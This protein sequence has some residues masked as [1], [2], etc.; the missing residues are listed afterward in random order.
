MGS[1]PFENN[2]HVHSKLKSLGLSD[3]NDSS[4]ENSEDQKAAFEN[5]FGG[6]T[7]S[8]SKRLTPN[9]KS[10]LIS[11][12]SCDA[13]QKT[14]KNKSTK[15]SAIHLISDTERDSSSS[16]NLSDLEERIKVEEEV[17]QIVAEEEEAE[18][19]N[20][21]TEETNEHDQLAAWLGKS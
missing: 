13:I 16:P 3:S 11:S 7:A 14:D 9:K 2:E 17:M 8:E 18:C 21:L 5:L 20:T 6:N 1:P 19:S 12:K 10:K 4:D 15:S